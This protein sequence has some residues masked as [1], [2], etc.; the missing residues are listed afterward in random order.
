MS[1]TLD[2]EVTQNNLS[3]IVVHLLKGVIYKEADSRRWDELVSLEHRIKDY[4]GVIGLRLILDQVECYAFLRS[5]EE[6][7]EEPSER[8]P[9]LI[10]RRQ[11]SFSLSLLLALLRKRLAEHDASG[12]NDRLVLSLEEIR[13]IMRL[14]IPSGSNEAKLVDQ[15]ETNVNKAIE[16][17]FMRRLSS[18]DEGGK[19]RYELR[20][21][22]KAFV[23]A[24][25]LSEFSERLEVYRKELVN[26]VEVNNDEI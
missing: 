13:E 20:R 18:G 19:Q 14:F 21:I 6:S 7:E 5:A 24:E 15:I 11:L 10:P 2:S 8:I 1:E 26:G 17:G 3:S 9:R 12:D 25:W 22:L 16:L 4:V 23:D